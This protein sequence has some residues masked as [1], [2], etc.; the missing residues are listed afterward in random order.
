MFELLL[1]AE[2]KGRSRSLEFD[3]T[4]L[5]CRAV[6]ATEPIEVPVEPPFVIQHTKLFINSDFVDAVSGRVRPSNRFCSSNICSLQDWLLCTF[7]VLLH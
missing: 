5:N 3:R 4:V 7:S 2:P 6:L 1:F